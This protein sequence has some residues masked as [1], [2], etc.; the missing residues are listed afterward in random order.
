MPRAAHAQTC[1]AGSSDPALRSRMLRMFGVTMELQVARERGSS[2]GQPVRTKPVLGGGGGGGGDCNC[3]GVQRRAWPALS[4][5]HVL[6]GLHGE[7]LSAQLTPYPRPRAASEGAPLGAPHSPPPK[8]VPSPFRRILCSDPVLPSRPLFCP[9]PAK[10]HPLSTV[11][12]PPLHPSLVATLA[13]HWPP[14]FSF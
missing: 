11:P 3:D 5:G 1:H 13:V 9:P 6:Y 12:C 2:P 7:D 10:P 8:L 14:S 4:P